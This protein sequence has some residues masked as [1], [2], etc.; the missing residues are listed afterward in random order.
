MRKVFLFS[1]LKTKREFMKILRED[2]CA[3]S[4]GVWNCLSKWV[5]GQPRAARDF[6]RGNTRRYL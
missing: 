5:R 3:I 1:A 4:E 6:A 2:F